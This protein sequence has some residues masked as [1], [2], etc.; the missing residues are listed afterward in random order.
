MPRVS[1]QVTTCVSLSTQG[2]EANN[3]SDRSNVSS[4]GRFVAFV[5]LAS[6]L[7]SN[8][9]NQ[10]VDVYVRDRATGVTTLV[11]ATPAG[12]AGA[13]FSYQASFSGDG[14][15]VAFSSLANNLVTPDTN[16]NWD[17]FVRDM[18]TGTTE[19]VSVTSAGV[20]G[21]G[22]NDGPAISADGRFVAFETY[23]SN[24]GASGGKAIVI[25][26]RI[27]G[28]TTLGSLNASGVAANGGCQLPVLS[29]DGRFLAF[30]SSSTNLVPG[31][32]PGPTQA[33]LR[34]RLTGVV[35]CVSVDSFGNPGNSW[36]SGGLA[37]SADGRY[38]AFQSEAWNL[39]PNDANGSQPDVFVHDSSTGTTVCVSVTA[40]GINGSFDSRA[41]SI[42]ASGRFVAFY[43]RSNNI[44]GG[45][46][47]G[48]EDVFVRDL[49]AGSTERIS[50]DPLGANL[51]LA[52]RDAAISA[53]GAVV[54]F[55]SADW[56]VAQPDLIVEWDIF[57]RERWTPTSA[58]EGC[59]GDGSGASCPCSNFGATG[60]GCASSTH[61]AGAHLSAR[62]HAGASI[63]Q[64]TLVLAADGVGGPAL[65]F[66]FSLLTGVP[67]GDGILCGAGTLSRLAVVFPTAGALEFPHWSTGP[68][69][70]VAGA[71]SAGSVVS[72][73]GW[74]RDADPA[75]CSGSTFNLTNAVTVAW[76]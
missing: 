32:T 33:F 21:I 39:V 57:A 49:L 46:S 2:A 55:A 15:F 11:S 9:Q 26:D 8:D 10:D 74:Y 52:S 5:T 71:L 45:D 18:V 68:Q 3:G 13:G 75:F 44:G 60:R 54:A 28:T 76:Q 47:N 24:L 17:V 59:F 34:D 61:P 72:Y 37:L 1:A 19:R 70:H 53:D 48:A 27:A 66:Q 58:V 22:L 20:Q 35:R 7:S 14:R 51:T 41:P 38:V 63:A 56:G 50:V 69:L 64:D 42:S 30:L 36:T 40:A 6:N 62:G 25:R 29:S 31:I 4:D 16:A 67:F 23:S 43:S 65:L 73:Q 12:F